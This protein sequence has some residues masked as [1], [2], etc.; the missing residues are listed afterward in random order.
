MKTLLARSSDFYH[1]VSKEMDIERE[2]KTLSK[3]VLSLVCLDR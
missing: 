2:D 1:L 3:G